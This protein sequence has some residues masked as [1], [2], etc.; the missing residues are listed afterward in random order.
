[1]FNIDNPFTMVVFIVAIVFGASVWRT[2]M[3]TRARR[4]RSSEDVALIA[5]L[6]EQVERL[7]DRVAVLE[8]LATDDDRSLAR[9]IEGLRRNPTK[10]VTR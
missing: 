10:D 1:V 7:T 3:V 8:R 6:T 2:H 9:E 4:G 5:S